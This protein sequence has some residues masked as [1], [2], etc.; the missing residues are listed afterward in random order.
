MKWIAI[1]LILIDAV[2]TY[3][4]VGHLGAREIVLLFVNQTPS[5]IWPF[6]FA[7]VLSVLYLTK[8]MKKYRWVEYVLHTAIFTH[9]VAVIN[10]TYW[11][12][13]YLLLR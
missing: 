8:F 11:F 4:A 1:S 6:A 9:A 12:L 3:V 10:N 13:L 7:K 2:L 5:L